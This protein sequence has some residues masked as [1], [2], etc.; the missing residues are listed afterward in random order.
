MVARLLQVKIARVVAVLS[1]PLLLLACN[2]PGNSTPATST[3]LPEIAMKQAV[4][5]SSNTLHI[6]SPQPG[7]AVTTTLTVH[8]EGTA[9]E[10]TFNVDLTVGSERVANVVVATDAPVGELCAFTATL[11]LAPVTAPTDGELRVYTTSPQDGQ[12]DQF[13]SVPVKLVPESATQP[14]IT[15]TTNL[16]EIRL[17]PNHG[18]AGKQVLIVGDNF[19]PN[20]G[21]EIHLGGLNTGATEHVYATFRSDASGAVRGA[22]VMP[23]SWPTGEKILLSQIVVLATTPDFLYKATEEFAYETEPA[24]PL[25]ED[26]P[27]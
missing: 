5:L 12:I 26:T 24:P 27:R 6:T 20:T 14:P 18:G 7:S 4:T 15:A 23:E 1:I 3:A 10:N 19:P 25:P 22:F 9:Y 13:T 21:V 11:Q 2:T 16:A 8:G 17:N